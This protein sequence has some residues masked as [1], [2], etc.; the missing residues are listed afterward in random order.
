MKKVNPFDYFTLITEEES[1]TVTG[2]VY[3]ADYSNKIGSQYVKPTEKA[4]KISREY[5]LGTKLASFEIKMFGKTPIL[6]LN[7]KTEPPYTPFTFDIKLGEA[8]E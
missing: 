3:L 1:E 8:D 4:K 6:Y 5:P 7:N 2:A